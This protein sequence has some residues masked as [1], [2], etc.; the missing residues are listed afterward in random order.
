MIDGVVQRAEPLVSPAGRRVD[1][2]HRGTEKRVGVAR[3]V[4]V[5]VPT[6]VPVLVQVH[7]EPLGRVRHGAHEH[8]LTFMERRQMRARPSNASDG[9]Q[10]LPH[11]LHR[12]VESCG[13][14]AP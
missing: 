1:F 3:D 10:W 14:R 12:D 7:I 4:E 11:C 5:E 13:E 2:R 6:G 9:L 8:E